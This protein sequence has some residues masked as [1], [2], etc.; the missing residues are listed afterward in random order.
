MEAP[1]PTRR[2][3]EDRRRATRCKGARCAAAQHERD[4][5]GSRDA[6]RIATRGGRG[7]PVAKTSAM[8]PHIGQ[9]SLIVS[10]WTLLA[11]AATA[12][13][14][15][16]QNPSPLFVSEGDGP[17]GHLPSVVLDL[18]QDGDLD[19]LTA[20]GRAVLNDGGGRFVLGAQ[21]PALGGAPVVA[22]F[23]GDGDSDVAA[24]GAGP[25]VFFLRNVGGAVVPVA[26]ATPPSLPAGVGV[27]S[28]SAPDLDGDGLADLVVSFVATSS[29]PPLAFLSTAPFVFVPAPPAIAAPLAAF[30]QVRAVADFDQDGD[31]DLLVDPGSVA[32]FVGASAVG[33]L[34]V[35]RNDGNALVALAAAVLPWLSP[36]VVVG[37][38]PADMDGDGDVDV[39]C[40]G[41]TTATPATPSGRIS[42]VL[43]NDGTG[44]SPG[45]STTPTF[46]IGALTDPLIG[47]FA[48]DADADGAA[49]IVRR[50]STVWTLYDVAPNGAPTATQSGYCANPASAV[51]AAFAR[52]FDG[53]GDR[54]LL[55]VQ[56]DGVVELRRGDG[57]GLLRATPRT[58]PAAFRAAS[59]AAV[60]DVDGDG[61]A[62]VVGGAQA[63]FGGL[64]TGPYSALN[65]GFGSFV[66]A[67]PTTNP[68]FYV[69]AIP[70]VATIDEDAD[71]D[72]DLIAVGVVGGGVVTRFRNDGPLGWSVSATTTENPDWIRVADFDG[73]GFEDYAFASRAAPGPTIRFGTG[74][75]SA[76]FGPFGV[77]PSRALAVADFDGDGDADVF[78]GTFYENV[79]GPF[80]PATIAPPAG[81]TVNFATPGDFDGDG[82]VDLAT[83]AGILLN[84]PTGFTVGPTVAWLAGSPAY[85]GGV[86]PAEAVDLDGDGALDLLGAC[87]WYR[88]LGSGAFAPPE[89]IAEPRVVNG[90]ETT[91]AFP[92]GRLHAG[93][94]DRDGD[95]DLVD[96]D[97]RVYWNRRRHLR[98]GSPARIGRVGTLELGGPPGAIAEVIV[99]TSRAAAPIAA[100]PWGFVF[101]EPSA[102]A[103]LTAFVLDAS[104]SATLALAVPNVPS[105][106]GLSLY[107][108]CAFPLEGR[109]SGLAQTPVVGF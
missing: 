79:G 18:D 36:V 5:R 69:G 13:A 54:D 85:P 107:W 22:D 16:G 91:L 73:D 29:P 9:E 64:P 101:I 52:D 97:K 43:G 38:V 48:V 76:T 78:D 50:L 77:A 96:E 108:Q 27:L 68:T 80:A 2:R 105:L 20:A 95:L 60:F 49:E 98:P 1:A 87:A 31:G 83:D 57:S 93:D 12:A 15:A 3:A 61:D 81:T 67:T 25:V 100:G 32:P 82:D 47:A 70:P 7:T 72:R 44:A 26:A 40:E 56:F 28:L 103:L 51:F 39:W 62:D 4:L 41:V 53:D 23:D 11:L 88:G 104:S 6:A 37:A 99:A 8:R 33:S 65:D 84:G 102:A 58:L 59:F 106:V 35:L 86:W 109:L 66:G 45:S 24:V 10:G 94:L 92:H 34:S 71:G 75:F 21:G 55:D 90:V 63:S 46:L 17:P 19:Y 74:G 14:L 42:F 30:R 89:I